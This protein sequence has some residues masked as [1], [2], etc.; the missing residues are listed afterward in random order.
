MPVTAAFYFP[1]PALIADAI[2]RDPI[3]IDALLTLGLAGGL[4]VAAVVVL[5]L[6][7]WTDQQM[8]E[9]DAEARRLAKAVAAEV[10]PRVPTLLSPAQRRY[11]TAGGARS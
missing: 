5:A 11:A 2:A 7:P 8:Q 9:V 4:V 3:A 10:A 6:L 1:V